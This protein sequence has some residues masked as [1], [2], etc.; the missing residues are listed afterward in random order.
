M[1]GA[2]PMTTE[3]LAAS[4]V[5]MKRLYEMLFNVPNNVV[6]EVTHAGEGTSVTVCPYKMEDEGMTAIDDVEVLFEIT[7]EGHL[8]E[9]DVELTEMVPAIEVLSRAMK[10]S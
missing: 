5:S 10:S 3:T 2:K 7:P 9:A 8:R 4:K 6:L 1:N